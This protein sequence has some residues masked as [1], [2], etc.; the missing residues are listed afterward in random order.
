MS[1]QK[2]IEL[3][4]ALRS[5][6]II[7][8]IPREKEKITTLQEAVTRQRV[9]LS[10][11]IYREMMEKKIH[12]PN[13]NLAKLFYALDTMFAEAHRVGELDKMAKLTI[14]DVIADFLFPGEELEGPLLLANKVEIFRNV[15]PYTGMPRDMNPLK[16]LEEVFVARTNR[17]IFFV[18]AGRKYG[19]VY[20]CVPPIERSIRGNICGISINV[21]AEQKASL[22]Y[23]ERRGIRNI[24][25][26]HSMGARGYAIV[27]SYDLARTWLILLGILLI[28]FSLVMYLLGVI[29]EVDKVIIIIV[30]GFILIILGFLLRRRALKVPAGQPIRFA[31]YGSSSLSILI[32]PYEKELTPIDDHYYLI[33]MYLHPG[34]S[35]DELKDWA[36]AIWKDIYDIY[37]EKTLK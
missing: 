14:S 11:A 24:Y 21:Y 13:E 4:D 37:S 22:Y 32:N 34:T 8:E 9:A 28:M 10:D 15:D 26:N 36:L 35:I 5:P 30:I 25:F 23:V 19:G 16:I 7:K 17:R 27:K 29:K 2:E 18:E 31:S 3:A 33:K 20:R 12:I 1:A 6:Q